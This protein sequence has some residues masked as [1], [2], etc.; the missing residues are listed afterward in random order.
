MTDVMTPQCCTGED[1]A[2]RITPSDN[3]KI[4]P[5]ALTQG[6]TGQEASGQEGS[7]RGVAVRL[8]L[9]LIWLYKHSLSPML[10][11][12]GARC[13]H[14]PGCSDYAADAFRCHGAWRGGWL[15]LARLLRCHPFG[16]HG[17]DPVPGQ[18]PDHRLAPWRYGDWAWTARPAFPERPDASAAVSDPAGP[19]TH[20]PLAQP[21][22]PPQHAVQS[23]FPGEPASAD[24]ASDRG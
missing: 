1:P 5:G 10:H 8:G 14:L 6:A 16:S 21:P 23:G 12:A 4:R 9:G 17:F 2:H 22:M 18:L 3:H 7:R 24:G 13:R 11:L 19:E 15:T 20:E